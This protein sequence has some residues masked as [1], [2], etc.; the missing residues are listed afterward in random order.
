MDDLVE[1][2]FGYVHMTGRFWHQHLV[3]EKSTGYP[4]LKLMTIE[5]SL[6]IILLMIP[7]SPSLEWCTTR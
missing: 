2:R 1:S 5:Y 3:G 4:P 7:N 6:Y